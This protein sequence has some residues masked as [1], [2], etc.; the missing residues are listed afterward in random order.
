MLFL[1]GSL[2][3]V[4]TLAVAMFMGLLVFGN[5]GGN[6]NTTTAAASWGF[7]NNNNVP[8]PRGLEQSPGGLLRGGS[9]LQESWNEKSDNFREYLHKKH[10]HGVAKAAEAEAA[11]QQQQQQQQEWNTPNNSSSSTSSSSQQQQ[12]SSYS[13]SEQSSSNFFQYPHMGSPPPVYYNIATSWSPPGGQRFVEYTDGSSPYSI[14]VQQQ[15]KSDDLARLRRVYVKKAMKFAWAGYEQ[16]AWGMDEILPISR[17]GTNNW[18][19]FAVTMIDSL[20]TL[21]LMDMKEEFYR[22]RDYVHETLNH[23]KGARSVSFFETTIRSVGG[24]LSAYDWSGDKIFL[25]SALDLARRLIK[26]FNDSPT[27][28]PFG[29]VNLQ[30][31]KSSNIAWAGNNAILAEF[32]T[33]QL[34]YR[35]LDVY[36]GTPETAEMRRKVEHV[37]EILR[38]MAPENGLFPY[39]MKNENSG[40]PA[41]ANDHITFG[42]M[43]D[44]FYE[45]MLKIWIQGGKMEPLYRQMYDKSIQGMHDELLF[46]SEP[47]GLY[48]IADKMGGAVDH[49]M[50]HLVCFMGGQLALGAYT[51]PRGLDSQRARRDLKTG[52]VRRWCRV[53]AYF[54]RERVFTLSFRSSFFSRRICLSALFN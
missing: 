8:P 48:Y 43:A 22:A 37:F 46:K 39:Y 50:D 19:G 1:F 6:G 42:A 40:K 54:V 28:I 53:V 14:S 41:F 25:E 45:Y 29:Q 17:R 23:D 15:Q 27:G 31:G 12:K 3:V 20:D 51:D 52:R 4:M 9:K 47:S 16:Y 36:V 38:D 18:G 11:A 33:V 2:T 49:K 5:T 34:E 44:S 24:L 10:D 13:R 32:G 35:W 30:T 21:W 7:N 26:A